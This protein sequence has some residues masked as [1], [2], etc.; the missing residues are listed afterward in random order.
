VITF[1]EGDAVHK[2]RGYKF[3]GIVLKPFRTMAGDLRYVVEMI[4]FEGPRQLARPSGLLHIFSGDQLA[5]GFNQ[6]AEWLDE[7]GDENH[8]QN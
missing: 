4:R 2:P 8:H 1:G 5:K 3:P 6:Q 7:P